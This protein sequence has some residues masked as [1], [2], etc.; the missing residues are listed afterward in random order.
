MNNPDRTSYLAGRT[1]DVMND[2][3]FFNY[4]FVE[5]SIQLVA[6]TIKSNTV[7][8]STQASTALCENSV[9]YYFWERKIFEQ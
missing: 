4:L 9:F 6:F 1:V 5:S 3:L 2:E 8:F 7:R